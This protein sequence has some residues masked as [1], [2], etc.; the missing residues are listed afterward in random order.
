MMIIYFDKAKLQWNPATTTMPDPPP[1]IVI[2]LKVGHYF[3][4]KK[5][6]AICSYFFED[7]T[8]QK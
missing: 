3:Y 5:H 8:L 1:K 4:F 2:I 6:I 7:S